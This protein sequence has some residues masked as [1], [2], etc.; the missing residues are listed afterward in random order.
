M[1]ILEHTLEP[2]FVHMPQPGDNCVC[3]G[4]EFK[5]FGYGHPEPVSCCSF[6]WPSTLSPIS[7][8]NNVTRQE[9]F[10]SPSLS[11]KTSAAERGVYLEKE[12]NCW[13]I[14]NCPSLTLLCP[15]SWQFLSLPLPSSASQGGVTNA[16]GIWLCVLFNSKMQAGL[17]AASCIFLCFDNQSE[18]LP[19]SVDTSG[20][21]SL[22]LRAWK[23]SHTN[24]S[25]ITWLRNIWA[26]FPF[27]NA[28][29][30]LQHL[31][32]LKMYVFS[33]VQVFKRGGVE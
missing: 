4:G 7:F 15:F 14:A 20:G 26:S 8:R 18:S 3:V 10:L 29:P 19:T 17:K 33:H 11:A 21:V 2:P 13:G 23:W 1:G 16:K 9:S 28:G 30:L 25:C 31:E 32:L 24:F 27:G 6:S 5:H 22:P 12:R